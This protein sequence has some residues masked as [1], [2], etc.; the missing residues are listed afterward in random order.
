MIA[1]LKFMIFEFSN[2]FVEMLRD[3]ETLK[4]SAAKYMLSTYVVYNE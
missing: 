4:A 1:V 3:P 2:F